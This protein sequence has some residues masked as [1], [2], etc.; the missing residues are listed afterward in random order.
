MLS[1][2]LQRFKY[3]QSKQKHSLI[4]RAKKPTLIADPTDDEPEVDESPS[5][6]R[7]C[8]GRR[9][10]FAMLQSAP[11]VVTFKDCSVIVKRVGYIE[12]AIRDGYSALTR[13][14]RKGERMASWI[15]RSLIKNCV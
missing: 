14:S 4:C 3:I 10:L 1:I 9:L 12:N 13:I 5:I 8:G 15:K 11:S 7:Q 2:F 6:K